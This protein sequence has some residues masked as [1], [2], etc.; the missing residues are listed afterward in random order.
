MCYHSVMR[1]WSIY[2]KYLD[3]KGLVALWREALL[4]QKVLSGKT[5]GYKHHP[6]LVRFRCS[7]HPIKAIGAYLSVILAEGERRGY[8]FDRSKILAPSGK[9]LIMTVNSQQIKYEYNHL[10]KKLKKRLA[11]HYN[12]KLKRPRPN[13]VFKVIP[14]EVEVWGIR[15]E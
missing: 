5:K 11:E 1:L 7:R 9:R 13:P 15:R 10:V 2:P 3:A 6:Q 8:S 12:T 4:A 14:G